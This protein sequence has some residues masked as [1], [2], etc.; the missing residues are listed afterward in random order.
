MSKERHSPPSNS[1]GGSPLANW[2][3]PSIWTRE[4]PFPYGRS[5]QKQRP[6][7]PVAYKLDSMLGFC[8]SEN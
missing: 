5:A 2:V 3:D 6:D 8:P 7:F 1:V 4:T